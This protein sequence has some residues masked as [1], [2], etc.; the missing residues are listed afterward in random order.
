MD[1]FRKEVVHAIGQE[2]LDAA[3]KIAEKHGIEVEYRGGS[4]DPATFS[5]KIRFTVPA[6]AAEDAKTNFE[7][8]ASLYDVNPE[9]LGK[10]FFHGTKEFKVVG[11]D[12]SKPKNCMMLV[13]VFSGKK[14]K[15]PPG[16]VRRFL[17]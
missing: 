8:Y 15:S 13:E 6:A 3:K 9:W 17:G 14:F 7:R 2:L 10:T 5:P 4:Y 1:R 12:T 16:Y 11:L